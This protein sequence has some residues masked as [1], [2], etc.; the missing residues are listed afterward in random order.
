M[1]IKTALWMCVLVLGWGGGVADSAAQEDAAKI[2]ERR[3]GSLIYENIPPI[4][5]EMRAGLRRYENARSALFQDWLD[6]GSMLILTRFA[7]GRQ[8]HVVRRPG[9]ARTQAT[10]FD[11]PISGA[12]AQPGAERFVYGRDTGG[13]EYFQLYHAPVSG[14]QAA[15][16]TQPGTRNEAMVFSPDGALLAWSRLSPG[17]PNWDIMV[18]DL[19]RPGV[20]RVALEGDGA[21]QPLSISSDKRRM[22]IEKYVSSI[23]SERWLLDLSSGKAQRLFPGEQVASYGGGEF[24]PDGDRVIVTTDAG[25]D[26]QRLV[27]LDLRN[28]K[29]RELVPGLR[30]DVEA[31]DL[32]PDGTLLAYA[33]NEDGYSTVEVRDLRRGGTLRPKGLPRGVLTGLKF[34]PDGNQIA[35]SLTLSAAGGDVWT[36]RIADGAIQRWTESELGG[37]DAGTLVEPTLV[38]VPSFDG[39]QVPMFVYK[40]RAI[41]GKAP[42]II[43]IHGGP[44]SQARP[45]FNSTFQYWVNELGAAVLFPNVRGS[46][47]YGRE[48]LAMDNGMK[49]EDAVRDIGAILDW[50]ARQPDLD[51]ERVVVH[52]ASY[53]GYMVLASLMHYSDRLAGAVDIVG[54]SNFITFLGNTEGYRRDLR[55]AEYGD[56]RDPQMRAHFER[57]SPRNHTQRMRKP[58][59]VAQG[60][61]DPRVPR[62]ESEEIVREL[63][64]RGGDVWCLVAE[65]EGHGFRKKSNENALREVE[66]LFLRSVF[67]LDRKQ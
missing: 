30:W 26:V 41:Q 24:T 53:G 3:V 39:L 34:S 15:A 12:A 43:K 20:P 31:F 21:M 62:S 16:I 22:L 52:G 51:A 42:V 6:D 65:D 44:E 33:V 49:R 58:L 45:A 29:I 9:G 56:E 13:D 48:R 38:H 5:Q 54:I 11:E 55:R 14:G 27:E 28:G 1:T 47:G 7:E 36:W 40:P 67:H 18:M 8:V 50:V 66:A 63:R 60:A 23:E 59:L 17:D 57:I 46:K 35:I 4:P 32:S 64:S 37:L 2:E 19:S 61:N 10:F 25:A